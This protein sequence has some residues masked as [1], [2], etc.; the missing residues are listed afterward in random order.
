MLDHAYWGPDS[1]GPNI[2]EGLPAFLQ[3]EMRAHIFNAILAPVST[4]KGCFPG[5]DRHT[6][7]MEHPSFE[8]LQNSILGCLWKTLWVFQMK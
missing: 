3:V 2:P 7:V 8:V 5:A 1:L 4:R 6:L